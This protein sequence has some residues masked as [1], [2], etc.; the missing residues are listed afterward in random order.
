MLAT[1]C[2]ARQAYPEDLRSSMSSSKDVSSSAFVG[3]H[4]GPRTLAPFGLGEDICCTILEVCCSEGTVISQHPLRV[5]KKAFQ[6]FERRRGIIKDDPKVFVFLPLSTLDSKGRLLYYSHEFLLIW[7]C[8]SGNKTGEYARIYCQSWKHVTSQFTKGWS[9]VGTSC[10]TWHA[11]TRSPSTY[12]ITT[13]A[14]A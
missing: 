11:I 5:R 1:A 12:L 13:T 7:F 6:S 9:F 8:P 3:P 4:S 14:K 10:I 2:N